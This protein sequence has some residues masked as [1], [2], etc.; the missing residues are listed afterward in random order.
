MGVGFER[1]FLNA[2]G[3]TLG[4][5]CANDNDIRP[6]LYQLLYGPSAGRANYPRFN[7]PAY[8]AT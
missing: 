4:F 2:P 8:N 1:G 6:R 3:R 7:L 5:C